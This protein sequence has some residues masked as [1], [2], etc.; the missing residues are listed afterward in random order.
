RIV[1]WR[2]DK[3]V[4]DVDTLQSLRQ[5][6]QTQGGTRWKLSAENSEQGGDDKST[7]VGRDVSG[8]KRQQRRKLS[9]RYREQDL[10]AG[11]DD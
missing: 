7:N 6:A 5:L 2:R 9:G 11:L 4:D 1:R 3:T 8:E 10:F